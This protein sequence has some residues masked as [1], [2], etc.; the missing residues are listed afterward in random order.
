MLAVGLSPTSTLV[1]SQVA[2]SFGIPFALVP[3]LLL[4][5]RVDVMGAFV[6]HRLTTAVA[7]LIAAIIV[8][9]N[10]FLIGS[11]FLG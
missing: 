7:A 2:L 4:T 6:N 3:M 10:V 11:I 8:A 1:L 5:R 9:L